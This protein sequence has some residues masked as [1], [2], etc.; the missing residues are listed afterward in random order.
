[1]RGVASF[2]DY[3]V[4]CTGTSNRMLQ[5]LAEAVKDG[6]RKELRL[7]SRIEG[8]PDFGW[9]LIDAGDII[10]HIFGPHERAYYNLEELWSKGRVV[11]QMQ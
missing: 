9:V 2:A 1:M 10:V 5:A 11:L 7:K 6:L 3:F 8:D 4:I